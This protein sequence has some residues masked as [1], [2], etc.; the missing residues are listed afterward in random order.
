MRYH[1][2]LHC[3]SKKSS[4]LFYISWNIIRAARTYNSRHLGSAERAAGNSVC[5]TTP[6][7]WLF[8][9]AGLFLGNE[10]PCP[11][12]ASDYCILFAL[13]STYSN[14]QPTTRLKLA[15]RSMFS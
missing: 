11:L 15:K 13:F 10:V 14:H 5:G 3:Y 12:L 6:H 4:P 2:Y 8:A 7:G 9:T 1:A